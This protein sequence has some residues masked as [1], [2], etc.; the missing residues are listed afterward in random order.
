MEEIVALGG[1][2]K[3][4]LTLP[5]DVAPKK[6]GRISLDEFCAQHGFPLRKVRNINE[7][8]AVDAIR[9]ADLDWLFVLES[10]IVGNQVLVAPRL[11]CLGMH[12]ALLPE[13]R[14]RAVIPWAILKG[15]DRT[16]LTLFKLD[17]GVD[18]GPIVEQV[19]ISVE[20]DETATALY[21]KMMDAHR[22]L[23]RLVWDDLLAG[24]VSL[25]EQDDSVATVWPGRKPEDGRIDETMSVAAVET[26]VRAVTHPYPG[27][28]WRDPAGR[29]LV[30]W[31]GH[32][33]R[34]EERSAPD[35]IILLRDGSYVIDEFDPLL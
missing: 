19:V 34:S 10:Q 1:D 31:S 6:S 11:G 3:I 5:D 18:T 26:L 35:R 30:V 24:A 7:T 4:V 28:R 33:Q 32:V 20:R 2:L 29:D 16:G 21:G 27:A 25:R 13:G 17:A 22:T 9:R 12:P 14:G 8:E 23:I 15:L